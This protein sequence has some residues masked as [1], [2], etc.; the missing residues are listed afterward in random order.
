[1]NAIILMLAMAFASALGASGQLMLS[2]VSELPI[3]A[4][5]FSMFA[6]GFAIF[7]G[8]AVIINIW[9]YKAG[10]KVSIAYPI[11]ALSYVFT[12]FLAW[13]FLG[14]QISGWS[15]AGTICILFGVSLIGW[16]AV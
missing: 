11:L 5:P 8:V 7:Y 4:M 3:K 14:E 6:W 13:K 12:L 1:M 15:I 2:K 10:L 16:G 9:V